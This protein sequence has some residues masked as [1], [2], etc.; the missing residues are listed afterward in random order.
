MSNI[1]EF[2]EQLGQDSR[3]RNATGLELQAA[4][5]QAGIEPA[6]HAALAGADRHSLE[7]QAGAATNVC[8]LVYPAEESGEG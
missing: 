8:C 1:I 5:A 3:L 2:L 4:L 6:V 7:T